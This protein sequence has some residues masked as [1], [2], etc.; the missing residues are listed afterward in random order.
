MPAFFAI[1]LGLILL[2]ILFARA[3]SGDHLFEQNIPSHAFCLLNLSDTIKIGHSRT[4]MSYATPLLHGQGGDHDHAHNALNELKQLTSEH[5]QVKA[6]LDSVK[7][8]P[9]PNHEYHGKEFATYL[10]TRNSK[11]QRLEELNEAIGEAKP[12]HLSSSADINI[13]RRNL[14]KQFKWLEEKP[15]SMS[16][17]LLNQNDY[18]SQGR[19]I[20]IL[21]REYENKKLLDRRAAY[22]P[23]RHIRNSAQRIRVSLQRKGGSTSRTTN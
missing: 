10:D 6:A 11:V 16:S 21:R 1:F 8:T 14:N 23:R 22:D 19:R 5:D 20:A 12:A 17:P 7:K 2:V 13:I 9:D 3:I 15:K 18:S 4:T